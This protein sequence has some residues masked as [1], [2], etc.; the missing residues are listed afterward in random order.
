MPS[1]IEI[2]LDD[3]RGIY[4]PRDFIRNY[5]EGH[6][7]GEVKGM[8]VENQNILMNP[9][10]EHYWE[11]WDEVRRDCRLVDTQGNEWYLWQDGGLFAIRSDLEEHEEE[12]RE[13]FGEN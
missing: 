5:V 6:W 10:H 4:I 3:H 12:Y 9:E 7:Q 13:F 11:A 1:K 8:T 2:L